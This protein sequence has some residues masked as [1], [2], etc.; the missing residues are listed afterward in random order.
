MSWDLFCKALV[1]ECASDF[2][3]YFAPNA[4]YVGMRETQ[5]QTRT[6]GPVDPREMRGDI[7]LEAELIGEHFAVDVEWQSTRDGK[8][9]ERLLGYSYEITRMQRL[10]VLPC[11]IYTQPVINLPR[12]PL[13]RGIP[14]DHAPRKRPMIWFDFES[15]DLCNT[16]TADLRAR[17]LDAFFVLMLLCKDG[18]TPAILDEILERLLRRQ[19]ERQESIA[20]AFFFAGKVLKS[21]KDRAFLER[22][23]MMLD[24]MLKDNWVYQKMLDEGRKE[25]LIK[26]RIEGIEKGLEEGL[27]KGLEEGRVVGLEE[28]RVEGI[29]NSIETVARARFPELLAYVKDQ[30]A[31]VADE[32][33]L[34]DILNV[35]VTAETASEVK[36]ALSALQ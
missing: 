23:Y 17:N 22:K 27:Q 12:A 25:G 28:G 1:K 32:G 6:D 3:A 20:A 14:I 26:G 36:Q 31:P 35:I 5:L 24:E 16:F 13:E 2:I 7:V 8:M 4:R 30:I 33:Q 34:Q 15:L 11:V 10:N 18:G 19:E 29:R 9:D 21:A